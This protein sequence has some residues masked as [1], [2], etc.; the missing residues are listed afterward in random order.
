M[1]TVATYFCDARYALDLSVGSRTRTCTDD[2]NVADAIGKF[3]GQA[4]TCV[5]KSLLGV[6]TWHLEITR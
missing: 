1:G 6:S 2:D 3:D 4:P 5:G